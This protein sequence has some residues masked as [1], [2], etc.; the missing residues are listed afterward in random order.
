M[1]RNKKIF[2]FYIFG[3]VA[4]LCWDLD[5]VRWIDGGRLLNYT[6][7]IGRDF[8]INKNPGTTRAANNCQGY[9]PGN[10][11]FYWSHM[12]DPLQSRNEAAYM[13]SI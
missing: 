1:M 3:K 13:W 6:T 12:W 4:T 9:L 2:F 8:V 7:K 5:Q 10:Y 11:M